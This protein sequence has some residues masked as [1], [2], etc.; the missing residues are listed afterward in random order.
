MFRRDPSLVPSYSAFLNDIFYSIKETE[1]FNYMF[2]YVWL[3][4]SVCSPANYT[5]AYEGQVSMK[6]GYRI[7]LFYVFGVSNGKFLDF[8]EQP[9]CHLGVPGQ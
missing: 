6:P 7:S 5:A 2:I 8:L 9:E 4:Q 1:L 3:P